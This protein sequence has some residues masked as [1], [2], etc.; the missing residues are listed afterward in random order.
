MQTAE[1]TTISFG[2]FELDPLHRRLLKH[3]R[4]VALKPK[5]FDLLLT[6]IES[7]GQVVSKNDLLDRVWANQFVE[8]NNLTVHVAALRK[9]LGETKTDNRYIVTV[10]GTGYKFVADLNGH[11]AAE[12]T[13]ESHSFEH[14]VFDEE[15]EVQTGEHDLSS[16]NGSGQL[17]S[18]SL[19]RPKTLVARIVEHRLAAGLIIAAMAAGLVGGGYFLGPQLRAGFASAPPFAQ[20]TVR[21][22]TTNGKVGLAALSPDGKLF[23]Y[24][25]DDLG[26]KSLWL[27]YVDGGNHL[28]LKPSA[29]ATYYELSFA[30]DSSSLYFS[31]RDEKN[32]TSSLYRIPVP[33]GISTKLLEN[34]GDFTLSP[35]G[36]QLAATRFDGESETVVI[37]SVEG[38]ESRELISFPK[39]EGPVGD[40][41]SW[42]ADGKRLALSIAQPGRI[43]RHELAVVEIAD[44]AI[45]RLP[46]TELREI[47][48]TAW[49][50][51]GSGLIVTAIEE[52]SHSSVPQYRLVHVSFPDGKTSAITTDRSNY[53]AS[54]HNDSGATLSLDA[55]GRS[56]LAVEH[57]QLSNVWVAPAEDLSAARQITFSSFGKYDG[58]WGLDWT[59]DG[60]IIY[61][62]SD[63][64][65]QHLSR[66]NSDGT[67]P[68][69][70]TAPSAGRGHVDSVLTVSNDGRY[71]LFHSNRIN[72]EFDIW[73]LDIDGSNPKQLTFGGKSFIP[74]PSPDG[75][76]VYYK[77]WM[78]GIGRLCRVPI[79]GGEPDCLTD[80]E[81]TWAS[82]SPDGKYLA[83][84]YITD[85]PRLA[86]FL[87][88]THE[89]LK[90]FD[91]PKTATL[92]M[93]SRWT[94]DG[95]SV[96]FRDQ[97]FGYWAQPIDGGH[98]YRLEGL[99][100]EKFYNFSWSRDGKWLAL[101]R[102]QEIRDVVLFRR[103]E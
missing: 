56:I 83:A 48:K 103:G 46:L 78:D 10:P 101:V 13:V 38:T 81:T 40:S 18:S 68:E 69:P 51:D 77:S 61:T 26:Q 79:D 93:G 31:L 33:G 70:L 66:M 91:L 14:V 3:G 44:G 86:I 62:T 72:G 50:D 4:P 88:Q 52:S 84:S 12:I 73:R 64:Q 47:T 58:L 7:R 94:A 37:S 92:Y 59:P 30:P 2:E 5:A 76:W 21:Q 85:K 98:A 99:P 16:T 90:Q 11:S 6:L 8:E 22:L 57:R 74:A 28:S 17:A 75:Q 35:D 49:M 60:R 43:Y 96:T 42:S 27:G 9:A 102:G 54:W 20:N 41:I 39:N 80:K 15:I 36:T 100:K 23:A 19:E 55:A 71:I 89:V 63:T 67:G 29:E 32:P 1:T 65:S 97:S 45:T 53:G 87:T 24:T 25:I 95:R 82:F 34:I